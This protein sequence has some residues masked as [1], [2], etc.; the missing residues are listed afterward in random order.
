MA[1]NGH[2]CSTAQNCELVHATENHDAGRF[3]R[4]SSR[5]GDSHHAHA[6]QGI[7]DDRDRNAHL[8]GIRDARCRRDG[9]PLISG[10]VRHTVALFRGLDRTMGSKR[11]AIVTLAGILE[12]RHRRPC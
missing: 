7:D 11:S 8:R 2:G 9:A 3:G 5:K 12:E 4:S 10:E 6:K 1:E